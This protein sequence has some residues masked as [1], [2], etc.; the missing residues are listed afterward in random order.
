M[1]F[2]SEYPEGAPFTEFRKGSSLRVSTRSFEH[3]EIG[4]RA[5]D[6]LYP[7]FFVVT[8]AMAILTEPRFSA[9]AKALDDALN[10]NTS[11]PAV[12]RALMQS[13]LWSTYDQLHGEYTSPDQSEVERHRRVLEDLLSR[14]IRK[15]ALT[16]EGIRSLPANYFAAMRRQSL[17]DIFNPASGWVEILWFPH[18]EHEAAADNRRVARVFLKPTHPS[19]DL[20]K[21]VDDQ[22]KENGDPIAD[23]DGV[24]LVIQLLLIDTQGRLMPTTLTTDVQIRLFPRTSAGTLQAAKVQMT[25]ISRRLLL[26]DPV[27]G[28]LAAEVEDS[29]AYLPAAGNDYTLASP[30]VAVQG[31][32]IQVHLRTRCALCHQED[33]TQLMTF[34][35]ALPPRFLTP[36]VRRLDPSA[37]QEAEDVIARKRRRADF[38]DLRAYFVKPS[39]WWWPF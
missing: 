33:L 1:R 37:N 13:D 14:L 29:P 36:P 35:I 6:P 10:E 39:P 23:L 8:G 4:D 20:Q 17:P 28:G 15:V 26:S 25:E 19:R 5:I 12:A 32:P 11:R 34:S 2:S 22:R 7:N 16:P 31:A 38:K 21:I 30:Q 24:A 9:F 3:L 27:S 18:R